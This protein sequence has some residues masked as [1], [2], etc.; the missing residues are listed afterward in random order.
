MRIRPCRSLLS[1]V[2]VIIAVLDAPFTAEQAP[3]GNQS[4]DRLKSRIEEAIP[5]AQGVMGVSIKHLESNTSLDVNGD[6][7]FPM[8]STF[9]FPCSS[10]C[11]RW[12]RL[13][14]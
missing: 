8:A 9:K 5:L 14:P 13:G 7:A 1:I 12:R 3:P 4:L 2:I 6:G 10:N 11:T